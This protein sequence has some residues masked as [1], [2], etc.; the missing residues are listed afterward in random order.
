M[1]F[2][3]PG[4]AAGFTAIVPSTNPLVSLTCSWKVVVNVIFG[5]VKTPLLFVVDV[6]DGAPTIVTIRLPAGNPVAMSWSEPVTVY[7]VLTVP[8]V[9]P[10]VVEPVVVDPVVVDPVVVLPVVVDPVVVFAPPL[11]P[12]PPPPPPQ[13]ASV[14]S[15]AASAATRVKIM[16]ARRTNKNICRSPRRSTR[17]AVFSLLKHGERGNTEAFPRSPLILPDDGSGAVFRAIAILRALAKRAALRGW[18]PFAL[19]LPYERACVPP[20]SL[21]RSS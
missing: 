2:T 6:N 18:S 19:L 15:A 16:P 13:P 5:M 1:F 21:F 3:L 10:V 17:V 12:P 7:G 4:N 9:E 14:A 8:V 11:S 20:P